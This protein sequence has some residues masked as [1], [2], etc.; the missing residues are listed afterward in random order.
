VACKIARANRSD[1]KVAQWATAIT[2]M[3]QFNFQG[4][5]QTA[6]PAWTYLFLESA[7]AA[8]YDNMVESSPWHCVVLGTLLCCHQ[9]LTCVVRPHGEAGRDNGLCQLC[10]HFPTTLRCLANPPHIFTHT[11]GSHESHWRKI[12]LRERAPTA[13]QIM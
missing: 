4:L 2:G 12:S 11:P 8:L 6:C 9:R 5:Y 13:A 7:I 3:A 1:F 10:A